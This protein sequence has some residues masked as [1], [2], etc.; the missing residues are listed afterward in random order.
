[1]HELTPNAKMTGQILLDGMNIYDKQVDPVM[2]RRR[3]GM[4]SKTQP[5]SNNV[6]LRQRCRWP[7]VDWN[8]ERQEP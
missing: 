3:V 4:V 7:S 8:K 1:M 6:H 2:V 5:L